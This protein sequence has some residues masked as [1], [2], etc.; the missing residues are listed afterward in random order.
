M[1]QD[2]A[3]PTT[4]RT[5]S[6]LDCIGTCVSLACAV[7]CMALP[8]VLYLLP[9]LGLSLL[10]EDQFEIAIIAVSLLIAVTSLCWGARIH[11]KRRTLLF[12]LVAAA[13]FILARTIGVNEHL[14][15]GHLS[16]EQHHSPLHWYLMALGGLSLAAG[17]LL[18]R[19]LCRS[20]PSCACD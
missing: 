17:H 19:R 5:L 3:A 9:F 4:T 12:V 14:T 18:N 2:Q 11:H 13:F 1:T 10:A 15:T 7:H 6:R 16:V 20:C 8:F